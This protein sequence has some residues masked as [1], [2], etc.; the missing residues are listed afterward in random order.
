MTNPAKKAKKF[1]SRHRVAVAIVGTGA[2]CLY[3]NRLALRQ[4][5]DFLKEIGQLDA[6]YTQGME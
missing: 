5:T 4:H 1:V 2:F 3:L 6:F